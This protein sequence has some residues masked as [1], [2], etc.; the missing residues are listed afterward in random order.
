MVVLPKYVPKIDMYL[1]S[2]PNTITHV[3][4]WIV[5]WPTLSYKYMCHARR[6]SDQGVAGTGFGVGV[7][8]CSP[9]RA[10]FGGLGPCFVPDGFFLMKIVSVSAKRLVTVLTEI[11]PFLCGQFLAGNS[12]NGFRKV[13]QLS[14]FTVTWLRKK[15][16][17]NL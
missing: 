3:R 5:I 6:C 8:V 13:L 10:T 15:P 14:K 16:T 9:T 4:F 1:K 7:C 12:R 2:P 17:T 11:P